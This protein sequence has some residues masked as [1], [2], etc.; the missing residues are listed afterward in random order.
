[1]YSELGKYA[2]RYNYDDINRTLILSDNIGS[3]EDI[4]AIDRAKLYGNL[5]TKVMNKDGKVNPLVPH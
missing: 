3:G 1:M 4:S 5:L 2:I